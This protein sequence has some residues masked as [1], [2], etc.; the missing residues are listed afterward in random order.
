MAGESA[1]E[2]AQRRREKA[3]RLAR[4]A[5]AWERGA[6]G[7]EATARALGA[8]L[9]P[10]WTVLHDLR[11]PGRPQANLDHVVVGP[12]VV[13]VVDSK[14][15]SGRIEVKGGVLRQNGRARTAAVRGAAEAAQVI[16]EV[17]GLGAPVIHP[18]LCFVRDQP[19]R[20]RVNGVALCTPADLVSMLTTRRAVLA[21]VEAQEAVRRLAPAHEMAVSTRRTASRRVGAMPDRATTRRPRRAASRRRSGGSPGR[22]LVGLAGMVGLVVVLLK[23]PEAVSTLVSSSADWLAARLMD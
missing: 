10:D 5:D 22:Q 11:W 6:D 19:L 12:G 7:E 4:S 15:W 14:N 21:P 16:V 2:V 1:R 18:V 3:E 13:F 8:L 20:G 9:A 23:E 17:T